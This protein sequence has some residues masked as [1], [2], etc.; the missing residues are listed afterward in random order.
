MKNGMSVIETDAELKRVWVS[1]LSNELIDDPM[2]T[3]QLQDALANYGND[4][5]IMMTIAWCKIK[6]FIPKW[7]RSQLRGTHS[8]DAPN[9]NS[10]SPRLHGTTRQ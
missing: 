6:G 5:N 10:G 2:D 4:T 1:A 3:A 9:T 7:S 8:S